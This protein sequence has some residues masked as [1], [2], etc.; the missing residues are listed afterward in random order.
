MGREEKPH[1]GSGVLANLL[2][3]ADETLTIPLQVGLVVRRHMVLHRA[4]LVGTAMKP[5]MRGDT[6]AREENFYCGPGKAHIH[7]LL[8]VLIRHGVVHAL[9]TDVVVILD[10]CHFPDCQLERSCRQR[11]QKELL[12]GKTGCPA[13]FSFLKWLVVE[14][15]QL[16]TDCLIQFHKGQKLAVAQSSQDPGRDHA[17]GALHKGLVLG[18]AG[19]GGENGGAVVLRHL[20]VGLVEHSLCT[21]VL[22]NTGL[23]VVRREDAGDAAEIPVGVDMAGN[24][25]FLLHAQE[26]LCVGVAA[27]WQHRHKQVGLQPFP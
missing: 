22:D 24:P 16:L 9:H 12:L 5:Q 1:H 14:G 2:R 20:L 17:D 23:E 19:P 21:G 26:S 11:L 8:D 27:V 10:G 18:T 4:V 3:P 7:L 6:G 15:F 25:G 13:A